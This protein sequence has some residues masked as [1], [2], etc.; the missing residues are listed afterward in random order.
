MDKQYESSSKVIFST[1]SAGEWVVNKE[2]TKYVLLEENLWAVWLPYTDELKEKL[3][4]KKLFIS[5][6]S[7]L[8]IWKNMP[9]F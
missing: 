7:G 5:L 3:S 9:F 8:W 1:A 2:K 6:T 4:C